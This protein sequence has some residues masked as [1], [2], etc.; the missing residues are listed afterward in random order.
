MNTSNLDDKQLA[1]L[2]LLALARDEANGRFSLPMGGLTNLRRVTALERLQNRRW[3]CLV[4][5]NIVPSGPPDVPYRI[6][7]L[8]D[9]AR[10]WMYEQLGTDA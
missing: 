8:S 1:E 10:K 7:M 5:V 6:F 2:E 3:V 4:D 9:D